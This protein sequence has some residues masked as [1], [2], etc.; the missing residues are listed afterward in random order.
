M[1]N[2][3]TS[4]EITIGGHKIQVTH[5][6]K[7]MFPDA[8]ITKLQVIEYYQKIAD[9]FLPLSS[10]RVVSLQRFPEGVENEGFYQKEAPD[11]FPEYIRRVHVPLREGDSAIQE[12]RLDNAA[13]LVYLAN[14]GVISI[15]TWL[16]R[17]ENLETPDRLI[18]DLD[19][20]HENDFPRVM[21]MAKQIRRHL[22]ALS[23]HPYPMITGSRGMHII[24]PVK[25]EATFDTVKIWAKK[26]A[27]EIVSRFPDILTMEIRKIKREGKI[28]LDI[29]R[30]DYG[31][32]AIAPY[33]LRARPGA[34]VATPLGW[35]EVNKEL[36]PDRYSLKNIFRRLAQIEDPWKGLQHQAMSLPQLPSP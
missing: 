34:P 19:P 29:L 17:A 33:A 26:I 10:G 7:V 14:Q 27:T 4:N 5:P 25:G 32:T 2:P 3:K 28:F 23:L 31:Q 20:A 6:D 18:F 1:P 16:S 9:Y 36:T 24:V 11:Y 15:H 13:S 22:E 30:N 12:L 8:R 21:E 35:H